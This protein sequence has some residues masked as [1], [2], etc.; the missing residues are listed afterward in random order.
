MVIA[1]IED[2]AVIQKILSSISNLNTIFPDNPQYEMRGDSAVDN[3]QHLTHDG[4]L[5]GKQKA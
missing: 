4:W 1:G 3:S 2:A 5:A